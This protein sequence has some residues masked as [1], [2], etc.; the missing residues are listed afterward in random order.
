[1]EIRIFRR[2]P[3]YDNHVR[4]R[5]YRY[6]MRAVSCMAK[7]Y[8]ITIADGDGPHHAITKRHTAADVLI[9]DGS[10]SCCLIDPIL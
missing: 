9:H 1:M 2:R 10:A 7:R 6:Q 3:V 4:T 5:V 8:Y